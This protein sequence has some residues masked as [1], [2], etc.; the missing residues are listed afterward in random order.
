MPTARHP[1]H[2]VQ[3]DAAV[4][5]AVHRC[6][7]WCAKMSLFSAGEDVGGNQ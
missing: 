6:D 5:F 1:I 7:A 2:R 4:R 3:A